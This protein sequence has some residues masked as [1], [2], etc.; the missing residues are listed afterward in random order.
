MSSADGAVDLKQTKK[1]HWTQRVN[2]ENRE[3]RVL[4]NKLVEELRKQGSDIVIQVGPSSSSATALGSQG[5][6]GDEQRPSED[7]GD[8]SDDSDDP[9]DFDDPFTSMEKKR[10]VVNVKCGFD[11]RRQGVFHV[12]EKWQV[13]HLSYIIADKWGIKPKF[14]RYVNNKDDPINKVL[15]FKENQI[16]DGDTLQMLLSIGGGGLVR[17][18][19]TKEQKV[20]KL[21][22]KARDFINRT[23]R[24]NKK[25]SD[26]DDFVFDVNIVAPEIKTFL[27]THRQKMDEVAFIQS[28]GRCVITLAIKGTETE[29]LQTIKEL[30]ERPMRN[31]DDTSET[32]ILKSMVMMFPTLNLIEESMRAMRATQRDLAVMSVN[33]YINK[34]HEEHGNDVRYTHASF[35]KEIE[36]E[37]LVREMRNNPASEQVGGDGNASSCAMS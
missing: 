17:P 32:R 20:Q 18:H 34:F 15:T 29:K 12:C 10:M 8:S 19:L 2:R 35:V 7:E 3:L 31:R 22:D 27:E 26:E 9:D 13:K 37:M 25:Q 5:G 1:E 14:Q 28:Q 21:K 16:E 33:M 24:D 23:G 36:K 30:M 6:E 11:E 4:N